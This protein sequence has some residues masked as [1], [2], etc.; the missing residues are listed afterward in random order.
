M[1]R[2]P[3]TTAVVRNLILGLFVLATL[4]VVA[5]SC[6]CLLSHAQGSICR[7]DTFG[8]FVKHPVSND[9]EL[10]LSR[11]RFLLSSCSL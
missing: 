11:Y 4:L 5:E 9:N 2:K 1:S 7:E 3:A 10:Q 6:S 8:K